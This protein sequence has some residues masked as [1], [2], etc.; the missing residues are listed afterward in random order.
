MK[1]E[2]LTNGLFTDYYKNGQIRVEGN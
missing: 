2:N 1:T